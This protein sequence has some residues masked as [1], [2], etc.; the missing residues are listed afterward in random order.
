MHKKTVIRDLVLEDSP[1]RPWWKRSRRDSRR[2]G[3]VDVFD[4]FNP[5]TETEEADVTTLA[6]IISSIKELVDDP[7]RESLLE[8]ANAS[9]VCVWDNIWERVCSELHSDD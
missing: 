9:A 8:A 4:H 7:V 2:M 5:L 3:V 1:P 6:N